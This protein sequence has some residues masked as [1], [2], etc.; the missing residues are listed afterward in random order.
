MSVA[1][2]KFGQRVISSA[3]NAI[4]HCTACDNQSL[5][6]FPKAY[7]R[8]DARRTVSLI[9]VGRLIARAALRRTESRGAHYREDYPGR[10]DIHWKRRVSDVRE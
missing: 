8:P 4:E 2:A 3:W 5:K 9:T 10:D 7:F 1:V 6:P